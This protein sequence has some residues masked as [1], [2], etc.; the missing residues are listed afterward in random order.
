MAPL[1]CDGYIIVVDTSP[2]EHDT[3]NG[4]VVVAW[5]KTHGL[6][7]A[8]LAINEGRESLVSANPEYSSL[9]VKTN[10]SPLRIVGKVLWWVGR[11]SAKA[12]AA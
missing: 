11:D 10:D 6:M 7:V 9:L 4:A 2:V 3:L 12:V 5:D 8:R 1:I